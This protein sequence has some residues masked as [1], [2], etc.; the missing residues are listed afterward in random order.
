M[1]VDWSLLMASTQTPAGRALQRMNEAL[2]M[3]VRPPVA[4]PT[5]DACPALTELNRAL[6][7][8]AEPNPLADAFKRN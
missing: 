4:F 5:L 6:A 3:A 1:V 7:A 2:V 8:T